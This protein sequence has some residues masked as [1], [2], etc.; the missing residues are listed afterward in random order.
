M[1]ASGLRPV[2]D[3]PPAARPRGGQANT[4]LRYVTAPPSAVAAQADPGRVP[5]SEGRPAGAAGRPAAETQGRA[6]SPPAVSQRTAV[7]NPP[8]PPPHAHQKQPQ[9][10]PQ[11]QPAPQAQARTASVPAP[12]PTSNFD[13]EFGDAYDPQF[14]AALDAIETQCSAGFQLVPAGP[15]APVAIAPSSAARPPAGAIVPA[16]ARPPILQQQPR[17]Y[18]PPAS[19][20]GPHR[21]PHVPNPPAPAAAA[22]TGAFRHHAASPARH[23][24]RRQP[25]EV[26]WRLPSCLAHAA[27]KPDTNRARSWQQP[28]SSSVSSSL[29]RS[30]ARRWG[31]TPSSRERSRHR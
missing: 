14:M 1:A 28:T 17:V 5:A 3:V 20:Q 26:P 2:G 18:V 7:H 24:P 15:Q 31:G 6:P 4:P 25:E 29:S 23:P 16:P 13:L 9:P 11:P 19:A 27:N 10:Q 30:G 12:S 21:P 22:Q 8:Q